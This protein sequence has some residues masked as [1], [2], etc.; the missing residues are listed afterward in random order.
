MRLDNPHVD[1]FLGAEAVEVRV[2]VGKLI[3]KDIRVGQDIKNLLAEA[4]LHLNNVLTK[5]VFTSQ[6]IR[7]REVVDLLEFTHG[8]V[9][10]RF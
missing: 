8:F 9:E 2:K 10:E 3:R 6:F 4:F 7:H 1:L 5:A